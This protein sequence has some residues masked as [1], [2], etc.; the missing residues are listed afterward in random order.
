MREAHSSQGIARGELRPDFDDDVLFDQILGA[1][2]LRMLVI[3]TS[4]DRRFTDELASQVFDGAQ[5]D[6][7]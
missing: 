4:L 5:Q 1:F 3:G 2:Y 7:L 6:R